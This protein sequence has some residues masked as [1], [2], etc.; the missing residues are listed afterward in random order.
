MCLENRK[1]TV[2]TASH[3]NSCQ[4]KLFQM[5][6]TNFIKDHVLLRIQAI[7]YQ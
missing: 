1:I 4:I 5:P 7:N 2:D 3:T 6:I